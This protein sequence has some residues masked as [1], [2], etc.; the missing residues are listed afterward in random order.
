[1]EREKFRALIRKIKDLFIEKKGY[2]SK[3]RLN[4]GKM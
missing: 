1:M 4:V 2:V 3:W